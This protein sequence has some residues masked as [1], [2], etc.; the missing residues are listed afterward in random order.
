MF[1]VEAG[2]KVWAVCAGME[3]RMETANVEEP[4]G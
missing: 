2:E 4:L 1:I 3:R